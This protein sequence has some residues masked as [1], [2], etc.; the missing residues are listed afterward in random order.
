MRRVLVF[1][2]GTTVAWMVAHYGTSWR[3]AVVR[4]T[5]TKVGRIG[6]PQ[7]PDASGLR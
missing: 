6:R 5:G 3:R 2:A 4:A 1:L 7:P